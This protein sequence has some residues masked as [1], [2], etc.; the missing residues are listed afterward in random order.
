M[1]VDR[2]PIGDSNVEELPI[3]RFTTLFVLSVFDDDDDDEDD[4][5]DDDDGNDDEDGDEDGADD[6]NDDIL[7]L[8][9]VLFLFC[10]FLLRR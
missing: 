7:R 8:L 6:T 3:L 5:E 4:D 1:T 10:L 2:I 9:I